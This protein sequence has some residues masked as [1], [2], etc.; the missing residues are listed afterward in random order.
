LL[1]AQTSGSLH[2]QRAILAALSVLEVLLPALQVFQGGHG[3]VGPV[4]QVA[5]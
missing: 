1:L 3:L 5:R 4:V 2:G